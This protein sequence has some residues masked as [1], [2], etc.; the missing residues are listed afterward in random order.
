MYAD[1]VEDDEEHYVAP[2]DFLASA[3]KSTAMVTDLASKGMKAE[4]EASSEAS[5][6]SS[7]VS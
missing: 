3:R 7:E 1:L 2:E 4:S 5:E 6:V